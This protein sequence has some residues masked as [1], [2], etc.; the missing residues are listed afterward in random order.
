LNQSGRYQVKDMN[1]YIEPL[2]DEL[3]KLWVGV[4]MYDISRRTGQ[5]RFQFHGT[6]SWTIHDAPRLTHFCGILLLY[7]LILYIFFEK[8]MHYLKL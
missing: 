4:T 7:F 2:I 1:V 3:L 8:I 6:L 5:R